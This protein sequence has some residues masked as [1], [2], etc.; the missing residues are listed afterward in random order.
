MAAKPNLNL[1]KIGHSP[2][3]DKLYLFR[4]GVNEKDVLDRRDAEADVFSAIISK[5]MH[6]APEGSSAM[7][8]MGD[9]EYIVSVKVKE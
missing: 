5:M 2:V 3:D 7:V 9:T 6:E 4:H 1:F 8:T